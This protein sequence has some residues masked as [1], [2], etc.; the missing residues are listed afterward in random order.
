[1]LNDPDG[2]EIVVTPNPAHLVIDLAKVD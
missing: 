2:V 1:L